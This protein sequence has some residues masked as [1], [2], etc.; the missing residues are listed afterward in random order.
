MIA[1]IIHLQQLCVKYQEQWAL[2]NIQGQI[3]KGSLIA[4]LGPN[5]G[6]KS[7]L[8]KTLAGLL[9]PVKGSCYMEGISAR[10]IGYLPQ[11]GEIDRSFPLTVSE[12]VAMGLTQHQ[13]FFGSLRG[14]GDQAIQAA[15]SQV[16]LCRQRHRLLHALSGG[17]LQRVLFA[18][19]AVQ[20]AEVILLDEPFAAIDHTTV[21]DLMAIIL[22]W[23]AQGR[24]ILMVTHDLE[25][26]RT[27][28]TEAMLLAKEMIAWGPTAEVLTSSHLKTAKSLS[29]HWENRLDSAMYEPF[30][31]SCS[32]K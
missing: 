26:V 14:V 3:L 24:T 21:Q 19:L 9:K 8:L 28:F 22:K 30:T 6:G 25:L 2:K 16:G 32:S 18:R 13:G 17:Q 1:P 12:V 11:Y 10:Q 7:T 4:V 29:C 15:L 23:H 31:T 20:Q 27:H 5:G